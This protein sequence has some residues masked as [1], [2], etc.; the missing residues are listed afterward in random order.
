[1][2]EAKKNNAEKFRLIGEESKVNLANKIELF[3]AEI[4]RL[5]FVIEGRSKYISDLEMYHRWY[6]DFVQRWMDEI[7]EAGCN[8]VMGKAEH[9][10][11]QT[12]E[13][14]REF[15]KGLYL[16]MASNYR[17]FL[18]PLDDNISEIVGLILKAR[19]G[20]KGKEK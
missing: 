14:Y 1:M 5:N 2:S 11:C 16:D 19:L 8:T 15:L 4:E 10:K 9:A 20:A 3:L 13:S 18:N 12:V 17:V 7:I 6:Q